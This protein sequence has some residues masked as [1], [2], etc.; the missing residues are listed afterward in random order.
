MQSAW[1]GAL[2]RTPPA[3]IS[4]ELLVQA[5]FVRAGLGFLRVAA[6]RAVFLGV[7]GGKL[8]T[9]LR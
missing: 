5:P 4:E 2:Q 7:D 6:L 9:A 8:P 1:L 3:P